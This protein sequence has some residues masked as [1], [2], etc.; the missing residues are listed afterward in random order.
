[1]SAAAATQDNAVKP[2]APGAEEAAKAGAGPKVKA[3]Q[4]CTDNEDVE[5]FGFKVRVVIY[6]TL[7]VCVCVCMY[8]CVSFEW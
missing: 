3:G 7:C 2:D 6:E 4:L 5:P 8:V 1:M